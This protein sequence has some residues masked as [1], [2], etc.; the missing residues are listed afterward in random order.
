LA[1]T[2]FVLNANLWRLDLRTGESKKLISSTYY[3]SN[4]QYSPDGRKIAFQSNRSGNLEVWTCDSDGSNCLQ[5]TSFKGP[6]CGAPSWSPDGRWIALDSRAEGQPEVYV[7]AA[8]GGTPRRMTNNPANDQNPTWSQDFRWIYFN[9]DRSG[10]YEIWKMPKDGGEAVQMTHSG[11]YVAF[12]SPDGKYLYYNKLRQRGIFRM[13]T[14]GGEETPVVPG[15]LF[16]PSF[17]LT[18]KGVYSIGADARTIQ[19]LD[20]ASGKVSTLATLDKGF[21]DHICV[22]P[23][24]AYFMWA[25]SDQSTQDLMLVEGFR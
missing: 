5:L 7:I 17:G 20:T 2:W 23:D 1:Y 16:D 18:S 14:E 21:I 8:D 22:S 15:A 13:P 10:Q 25:Q 24:D 6:Q 19:F 12:E 4:P 9:S 3:S 11:G